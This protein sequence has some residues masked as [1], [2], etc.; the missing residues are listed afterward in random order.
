MA[1][2]KLSKLSLLA[3]NP[4]K[5]TG[6]VGEWKAHGVTHLLVHCDN[7]ACMRTGKLKLA[8]HFDHMT[9]EGIRRAVYCP[10]CRKFGRDDKNLDIRPEWP[11][12]EGPRKSAESA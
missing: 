9:L 3:M 2:S 11:A 1:R 10:A 8:D 7:H 5:L 6:T 12:Y 4:H